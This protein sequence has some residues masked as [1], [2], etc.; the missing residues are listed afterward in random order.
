[1]FENILVPLDGSELA[2]CVLPHVAALTEA[3][4][5]QV[6]LLRVLEHVSENGSTPIDP[7]EWHIVQAEAEA[8]VEN[9]AERL[10]QVG[11]KPQIKL[12]E[13]SAAERI[14]EYAQ[15][16]DIDLVVLSSHGR[17]GL[18][19]WNVSSVVQKVIHNVR[20][21]VMIVRAYQVNPIQLGALHY[22]RLLLPL[23]CSQRAECI[24]PAATLLAR[25]HKAKLIMAH[26]VR[27]PDMPQRMPLSD[28]DRHIIQEL[29]DRKRKGAAQYLDEI[30]S[31]K[32]LEVETRLVVSSDVAVALQ[33]IA[34]QEKVDMVML[35]AH[36]MSGD[37]RRTY[38]SIALGFI[39]YG[40]T[41]LLIHQDIPAEQLEPTEAERA[42]KERKGH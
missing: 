24:L 9:V 22:E 27:R 11:I 41:P 34:T 30:A 17:T 40:S 23:D 6:T 13:G 29:V 39:T 38:G 12:L 37:G 18:S 7:L 8:Y 42:S 10:Q 35:C 26:V 1:M 33:E 5:A 32:D 28:D 20:R 2:E 15:N 31:R 21:S 19:R 4:D 16:N 25:H 14:V 3:F 36:G